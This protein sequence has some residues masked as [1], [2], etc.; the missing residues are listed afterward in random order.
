MRKKEMMRWH[1][2]SLLAAT[3]PDAVSNLFYRTEEA[4]WARSNISQSP[5]ACQTFFE[6]F[7]FSSYKSRS[8]RP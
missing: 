5:I 4:R 2:S 8:R 1:Q 7:S 3:F 6:V